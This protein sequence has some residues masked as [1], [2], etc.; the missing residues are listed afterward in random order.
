M[1]RFASVKD[2]LLNKH[3]WD[4]HTYWIQSCV[5]ENKV[6]YRRPTNNISSGF[7]L[8]NRIEMREYAVWFPK[9]TALCVGVL[10]GSGD[11]TQSQWHWSD[12]PLLLTSPRTINYYLRWRCG[13]D[14]NCHD[15]DSKT[16]KTILTSANFD[17]M[18][19]KNL[20]LSE[21]GLKVRLQ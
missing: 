6:S 4:E 7:G 18:L 1:L 11:C 10:C 19:P 5:D 15:Y 20:G 21:Q 12:T 2:T 16:K 8:S 13:S 3:L 9:P 17:Y 14:S